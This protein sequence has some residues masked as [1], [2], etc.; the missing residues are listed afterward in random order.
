M[1][2]KKLRLG[3]GKIESN[4]YVDLGLHSAQ[5]LSIIHSSMSYWARIEFYW[6]LIISVASSLLVVI[7]SIKAVTVVSSD[8][9]QVPKPYLYL[10]GSLIASVVGISVPFLLERFIDNR[11]KAERKEVIERVRSKERELFKM[12]DLDFD[13]ITKRRELDAGQTV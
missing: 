10:I 13:S 6:S 3:K 11:R 5:R 4:H 2:S 7:F 12:L 1:K 9:P 8:L